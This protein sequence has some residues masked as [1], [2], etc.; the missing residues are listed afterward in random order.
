MK[1]AIIGRS[2]ILFESMELLLKQG[3][4]VPLIIT[5]K[6]AKEYSKTAKDYKKLAKKI[7]AKYIY[8]NNLDKNLKQISEIKCEIAISM[9]YTSII[10]RDV[11]S[12]FKNGILNAH[13]GDLPRYRGNACQAWALIN[14]ENKIANCIHFMVGG[15]IDS[16][17]IVERKYFKININTKITDCIKWMRKKIPI[18]FLNS[19]KKLEKNPKYFLEKQSRNVKDILRCYPRIPE[20]GKINWEKS[21]VEILRLINAT[22]KPYTGAFTFFNKKKLI[23]W[24]A[25][26]FKDKENYCSEVGQVASK[27]KDGSIIIV[28][29][30]GKLKIKKVEYNNLITNPGI[31]IK[32]TRTRL[33]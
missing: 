22:N 6:E 27:E 30:K 25:E 28:T 29:G 4:E 33:K 24:E 10:S 21:N 13:G 19:I 32:S 7:N 9:N 5:S 1:V 2:E 26:L 18:M 14:G 8:S 20:D 16:G 23:I 17:N 11:I 15:E 12:L 31:I 3:Y